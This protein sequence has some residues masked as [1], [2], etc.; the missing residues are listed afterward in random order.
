MEKESV[1]NNV[2]Q[3]LSD[4]SMEELSVVLPVEYVIKTVLMTQFLKTAMVDML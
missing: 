3:K 4:L 1:L 2:L